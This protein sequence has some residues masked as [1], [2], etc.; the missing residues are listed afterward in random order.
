MKLRKSTSSDTNLKFRR[1]SVLV[2]VLVILIITVVILS[3][4]W[5]L[6]GLRLKGYP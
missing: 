5:F 1:G 6:L 2:A 4:L 3:K